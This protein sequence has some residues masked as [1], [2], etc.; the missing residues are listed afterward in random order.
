MDDNIGLCISYKWRVQGTLPVY[1]FLFSHKHSVIS[2]RQNIRISPVSVCVLAPM[3][4]LLAVG[5]FNHVR[6]P[7]SSHSCPSGFTSKAPCYCNASL[8]AL[9]YSRNFLSFLR[10]L[11]CS[12]SAFFSVLFCFLDDEQPSLVAR[13]LLLWRSGIAFQAMVLSHFHWSGFICHPGV[14]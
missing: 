13:Y 12:V 6:S 1:V 4:Q 11:K 9:L 3:D 8:C 10:T 5:E 2:V 14:G 7:A